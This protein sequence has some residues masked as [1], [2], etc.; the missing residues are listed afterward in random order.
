MS[1]WGTAYKF[2]WVVLVLLAIVGVL[3]LFLPKYSTFCKMRR[4][5]AEDLAE[6]RRM[7]AR[8]SELHKNQEQ[9]LT[10]PAFVERTARDEGRVKENEIVFKHTNR[11]GRAPSR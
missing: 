1:R 3:C 6:N 8:I 9:F 4:Q 5:H 10:E 7:E 11:Q 2:G